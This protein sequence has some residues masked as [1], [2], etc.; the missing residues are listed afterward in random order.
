VYVSRGVL[1][2]SNAALV[3]AAVELAH[4][5]GREV[6]TQQE[7]TALLGLSAHS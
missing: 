3:H 5:V 2:P 6:A 4:A 7:T 1:A